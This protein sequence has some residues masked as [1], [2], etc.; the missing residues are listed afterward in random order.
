MINDSLDIWAQDSMFLLDQLQISEN[1]NIPEIFWN[2]L[3][4]NG[5]P[6]PPG[7][8]FYQVRSDR[9]AVTQKLVILP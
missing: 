6:V 1:D 8:Y 3:D 9:H 2:G 7:D 4:F 5:E